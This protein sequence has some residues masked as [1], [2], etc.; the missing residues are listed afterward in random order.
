MSLSKELEEYQLLSHSDLDTIFDALQ[1]FSCK[2]IVYENHE[3]CPLHMCCR[4]CL[5]HTECVLERNNF[6]HQLLQY[7][8]LPC[9]NRK[10]GCTLAFDKQML[11]EH[12]NLCYY[13]RFKCPLECGLEISQAEFQEHVSSYLHQLKSM[14]VKSTEQFE[15]SVTFESGKGCFIWI[16]EEWGVFV[17]Q[18]IYNPSSYSTSYS[19]QFAGT[20]EEA[21]RFRYSIRLF[22]D[23][24]SF[25]YSGNVE[26]L[27][28]L[29]RGL[30]KRGSCMVISGLRDE[31]QEEEII[32]I[33]L[34]FL[35]DSRYDI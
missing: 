29:P 28:F 3:I 35:Q 15:I 7:I 33:S 25:C 18:R 5:C 16:V 34:Q 6:L 24:R 22:H 10:E 13:A 19:V 30:A 14:K 32:H 27:A 23:N 31:P 8:P 20:I 9:K 21:Y 1:C 11:F 2:R 12:L 4:E 17:C 26:P